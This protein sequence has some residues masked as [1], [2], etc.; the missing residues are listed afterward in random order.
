MKNKLTDLFEVSVKYILLKEG[1]VEDLITRNPDY[2]EQIKQ[3]ADADP[4]GNQ[5]YL[6]WEL[7]QLKL[8]EP[9]QE[10]IETVGNF[11][12]VANRMEEKDINRYP[13]LNDLRMAIENLGM[14]KTAQKQVIKGG[15]DK[16]YEDDRFFILQPR[17]QE[18]SCQYGAGTTWCIAASRSG[19]YFNDYTGNYNWHF[20]FLISKNPTAEERAKGL[21][22]IAIPFA[23]AT[24]DIDTRELKNSKQDQN[25]RSVADLKKFMGASFE[26]AMA[27][28]KSNL[29]TLG[30]APAWVNKTAIQKLS[31]AGPAQLSSIVKGILDKNPGQSYLINEVVPQ[32]VAA[33]AGSKAVG[34]SLEMI[35]KT[36]FSDEQKMMLISK[37][38]EERYG[39]RIEGMEELK[40]EP[41][42]IKLSKD[43][44]RIIGK[45]PVAAFSEMSLG[46]LGKIIDINPFMQT[47]YDIIR[48]TGKL[49]DGD[50]AA[51]NI[52]DL[53]KAN[54]KDIPQAVFDII[55]QNYVEENKSLEFIWNHPL[56]NDDIKKIFAAHYN[57]R[58]FM[59]K[60]YQD[61]KVLLWL[62]ERNED[63]QSDI[64][65]QLNNVC[66]EQKK[67]G[68]NRLP[69]EYYPIFWYIQDHPVEPKIAVWAKHF[70]QTLGVPH[71]PNKT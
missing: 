53:I 26:P 65:T 24:G 60:N 71:N 63:T 28:C 21:E 9:V 69:P 42:M 68:G 49:P 66:N 43:L 34:E 16:I 36:L 7:R 5:K 48:A 15:A 52:F 23:V 39:R 44:M 22:K 20:Y 1:K 59:A 3:M 11:H 67:N 51:S 41:I 56:R 64:F 57:G 8:G 54:T 19:N 29:A 33:P 2:S 18:A 35:Y 31:S 32:L 62:A 30:D 4:S 10:I 27:A 40:K 37:L 13:S 70:R 50:R 6:T 12:G 55:A 61:P 45:N 58:K 14:S 46:S 47:I 38:G 25:M 17:T